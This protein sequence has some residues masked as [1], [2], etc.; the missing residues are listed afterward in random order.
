[1]QVAVNHASLAET[2]CKAKI[3]KKQRKLV[4]FSTAATHL[5]PRVKQQL[6]KQ[7]GELGTSEEAGL[8]QIGGNG[9]LVCLS[10]TLSS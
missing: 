8:G 6:F 7:L 9:Y 3:Y 2:K 10:T 1:M 5:L 4:K